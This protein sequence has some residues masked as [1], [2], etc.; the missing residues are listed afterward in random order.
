[1]DA[2]FLTDTHGSVGKRAAS[3]GTQHALDS[4]PRGYTGYWSDMAASVRDVG[5]VGILL[6][7]EFARRV[8][9]DSGSVRWE[10]DIDQGRA[11][12][13]TLTG[14]QGAL[15]L[16]VVYMPAGE[17]PDDRQARIALMDRLHARLRPGYQA[18]SILAGDWNFVPSRP[19]RWCK[20]TGTYT[21]Q[22]DSRDAAHFK[23]LFQ[24][25]GYEAVIELE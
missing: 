15:D 7:D 12:R 13:L 23:R 11:G 14:P 5:G 17:T 16:Y 18:W 2:I 4:I 6:S 19:D 8:T 20:D 1:M 22:K 10:G 3:L 21:G 9:G 25:P 24:S